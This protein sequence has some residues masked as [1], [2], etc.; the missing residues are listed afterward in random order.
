MLPPGHVYRNSGHFY[1][2]SDLNTVHI[3]SLEKM[4]MILKQDKL[5]WT[6][7]IVD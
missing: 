2:N 5:D 7:F 3:L 6:T 1:Q 4:K